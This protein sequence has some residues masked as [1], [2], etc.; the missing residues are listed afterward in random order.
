ME[1]LTERLEKKTTL[2]ERLAEKQVFV[3]IN[4]PSI[5]VYEGIADP[6][7]VEVRAKDVLKLARENELPIKTVEKFY[8]RITGDKEMQWADIIS[9]PVTDKEMLEKSFIAKGKLFRRQFGLPEPWETYMWQASQRPG[10]TIGEQN[11]LEQYYK[12]NPHKR[13][14]QY[15]NFFD[16]ILR[17]LGGGTLNVASGF[18]GT[19]A[20]GIE[21]TW[22]AAEDTLLSTEN[23]H[24]WAQQLHDK[25]KEPAYAPAEEGGWKGF[26]AAAVG[27]AAPYMGAA[28]GATVVSGTPLAAFGVAFAVEGDNAYRDAIAAGASEE[29]AQLRRFL[30]GT[31]NGAIEQM[32]ITQVWKFAKTGTGSA[33]YILKAAE[34]KAWRKLIA[35]GADFTYE[36][37]KHASREGLEEALQE[38]TSIAA[39]AEFEPEIWD[40][41]RYRIFSAGLGGGV[42]G[43]I[44]GTGGKVFAGRATIPSS[45]RLSAA[46]QKKLNVSKELGDYVATKVDEGMSIAEA[47]KILSQAKVLGEESVLA[48]VE[49]PT[50]IVEKP[51]EA[52]PKPSKPKIRPTEPTGEAIEKKAPVKPT[53]EAKKPKVVKKP[54][55]PKEVEPAVKLLGGVDPISQIKIA[56]SEAK[57]VRPITEAKQAAERKRRVGA[58]AGALKSSIAKGTPTDEAI[59][60]STGLLKGEL[61][62]YDQLYTPVEDILEPGAK[63]A[64]YRK[65]YEHPG[66]QY[67][68]VLNTATAFKKLLAGTS[69]TPT[70]IT[71]IETVFGK[72]FSDI[73]KERAIKSS[74]YDRA[75]AI[76]K[77]G[78][79]TGIKTS[80]INITSTMSHS[81]TET[82]KDVPSAFYDR[83]FKLFTG[84]RTLAFTTRGV[85]SGVIEGVDK[86][87]KYMKTG[88]DERHVGG[89][90]GDK[91][92]Y[93][94]IGMG[95]SKIAQGLQIYVET[96]FHLLGAEDQPFFYGNFGRSLRSQAIAQAMNKELKGKER[97]VYADKKVANPTD[98]MLIAAAHDAEVAVFQNR[99][100][101]G[102]IAKAVQKV[103][104]GEI[105]VPFGRTPS[106]V[107]MQIINYSPVG[108]IKAVTEN[109][110]KGK[111]NQRQFSQALGRATIGTAALYLGTLLFK[112]GL[113][114]LDWP[115]TERERELWKLEGRSANSIKIGDKW[116][117]IQ[118]LGPVGNAL[119]IGG[120]FQKALTAEGS[121][122]KAI[123]TAMSGGAKSFSEQTF[124]RGVNQA[125]D[126][127][128]S[129]ERSFGNW[130]TSMAGSA[131]PTIIAD[132]ARAA[133]EQERRAVG[134]KERIISR[135]PIA[136]EGL[137]P[138]IDVF[139][140][141]LPRY[142]GNVFEVMADPSRPSKI[143]EDVVIDE[144]RRLSVVGIKASPTL[145]GDKKGYEALTAKENTRLWQRAG[146]LTY[147][148]LLALIDNSDYKKTNDEEKGKL[149][150][151]VVK[152]AKD[153]ARAEI[154]RIKINQGADI[155]K[156]KEGGLLNDDVVKVLINL[157][158]R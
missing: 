113:M 106:A 73:T 89:K 111:F 76:W 31:I 145:L 43:L 97:K 117:S 152:K 32:Q 142:G 137:E 33:K 125:V 52:L 149:I 107:A 41:A 1:T 78:L 28:V 92:D 29:D 121:P 12:T 18:I 101:F 157:E 69:L 127:L 102:D 126:A 139:G 115:D 90:I 98:E 109:I 112:K 4:I 93:K 71:N 5:N 70:D 153:E 84:E 144:L 103:K 58:A 51:P 151:F 13:P 158:R 143:R 23:L 130:F 120:H 155:I 85:S 156:L 61:T 60:K 114:T 8:D 66:L 118:V 154:A 40:T 34:R 64:A 124:V 65:I 81:V 24:R 148:V 141:D 59:F 39:Q 129:P 55:K 10:F 134:P 44:Y 7:D 21:Q 49:E 11:A 22:G 2:S 30:V 38:F 62:E 110:G 82:A 68:E 146:E 14:R 36:A 94:K 16:E 50:E 80:G 63:E 74:L 128:A 132:I 96:I 54:V 15:K 77:A 91:Y 3:D 119:I 67:F 26:V 100:T 57:K 95:K 131:V 150:N 122:T 83:F 48:E 75:I 53:V 138:K 46:L 133:D 123:V 108:A 17:N 35:R 140:N 37:A 105:I 19:I 42:V 79:L 45:E 147:I 116:R 56:L 6:Q 88:I 87:W 27:Q 25:A 9:E 104:G 72:A 99:T 20:I 86:G 135:I 47:D 136:R